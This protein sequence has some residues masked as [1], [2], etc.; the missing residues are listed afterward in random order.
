MMGQLIANRYTCGRVIGTGGMSKIYRARDEQT[1]REVALKMLQFEASL[2]PP[3]ERRLMREGE[4][5]S[6]VSHR[7]VVKLLD[8]S[9]STD[10]HGAFLVL[11]LLEGADLWSTS[12]AHG[13]RFSVKRVLSFGIDVCDGLAA[14][15]ARGI[16]HR[17]L[18][19][20]N[21]FVTVLPKG[22]SVKVIDLGI[23][24]LMADPPDVEHDRC[25]GSPGY[26]SPEQILRAPK[27]DGR[28]DIWAFGVVMFEL[29]T[30]VAPFLDEE[31]V[32]SGKC[33]PLRQWRSDASE[34]VA[35]IVHS[36]LA[37]DPKNR[38][39][40]AAVLGRALRRERALCKIENEVQ[41]T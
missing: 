13:G 37:V 41:V 30:D 23:S 4:I 10:R 34:G 11:E 14:L 9:P 28:A 36:C 5:L 31:Q 39:K 7:N 20:E 32:L 22:W 35:S 15:H 12:R 8:R 33:T 18:K 16:V 6:R 19:P 24:K 25:V 2:K 38:F 40:S 26:L 29:L 3:C 21:L 27:I 1:G 17:D